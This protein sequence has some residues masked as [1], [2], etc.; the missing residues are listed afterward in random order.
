MSVG[1]FCTSMN[2]AGLGGSWMEQTPHGL[3]GLSSTRSLGGAWLKDESYGKNSFLLLKLSNTL[4]PTNRS[5]GLHDPHESASLRAHLVLPPKFLE[6]MCPPKNSH[7]QHQE[8][9]R[10][11]KPEGHIWFS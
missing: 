1:M 7:L 3:A 5:P 2:D 4:P 11:E 9:G 10:V 6:T 8:G